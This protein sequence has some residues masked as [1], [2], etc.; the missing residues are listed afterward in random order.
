MRFHLI[1]LLVVPNVVER[2]INQPLIAVER[3][4]H[5]ER[6]LVIPRPDNPLIVA[7]DVSDLEAAE[8]MA[9]RLD[10]EAGLL[11]VGLE[12]RP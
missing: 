7:L 12:L 3:P 1:D 9:R 4:E 2:N 6:V 5:R 11:K 10:G 8:T